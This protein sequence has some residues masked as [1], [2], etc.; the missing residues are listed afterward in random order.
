MSRDIYY[1]DVKVFG[2]QRTVDV[3]VDL[4]AYT[5]LIPRSCLNVVHTS[6]SSCT[7]P[8]LSLLFTPARSSES[9][10]LCFVAGSDDRSLRGR[11]WSPATSR[12][13]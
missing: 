8:P 6:L 10:N 7:L 13:K 12:S 1:R 5:L 2:K 9:R 11:D 4:L 3:I